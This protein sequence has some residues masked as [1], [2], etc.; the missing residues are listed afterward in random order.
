MINFVKRHYKII[1]PVFA[2]ILVSIIGFFTYDKEESVVV[3]QTVTEKKTVEKKEEKT[4]TVF[5]DIKGAVNAPGVY[6]ID[7][8]KRIMD[9][10]NLAGGLTNKASTINLNLS[11]KVEDEM[12]IVIYTK[13][14]LNE[15]QKKNDDVSTASCASLEC[16]CPDKNNAAC[17]NKNSE[18]TVVTDKV[19]I[20]TA[21]KEQLM[22]LTGIGEAKAN[23]IIAYRNE[24]GKF[25]DISEIKNVSGIGDSLYEQIKNDITI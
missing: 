19:S 5:V 16:V 3:A 22:T 6:E 25:N 8:D 7:S 20:N 14:E 24:K 2:L 18:S 1:L 17:I 9:V 21:T 13:S 4:S 10:I 23:A 15:Y 11:K 12:Y